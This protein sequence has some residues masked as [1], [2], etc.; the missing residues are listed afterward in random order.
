MRK[1]MRKIPLKFCEYTHPLRGSLGRLVGPS[2]G[3]KVNQSIRTGR[4]VKGCSPWVASP[5]G[6]VGITLI[7]IAEASLTTIN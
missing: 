3:E 1:V 6:R 4:G 2:L 7:T 5:W